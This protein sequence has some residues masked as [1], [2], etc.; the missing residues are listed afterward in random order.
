M[1]M[2]TLF[3]DIPPL[4]H[5]LGS[6]FQRLLRFWKICSDSVPNCLHYLFVLL[7]RSINGFAEMNC[8]GDGSAPTD[9][10]YEVK[11]LDFVCISDRHGHDRRI[12]CLCHLEGTL[13][14]RAKATITTARSLGECDEIH[15][16]LKILNSLLVCIELTSTRR[17]VQHHMASSSERLGKDGNLQ[18]LLF[19]NY[20]VVPPSH[21]NAD[22]RN[23][24][25]RAV[26]GNKHD[27]SAIFLENLLDVLHPGYLGRATH[28][29]HQRCGPN[30]TESNRHAP[31]L[32]HLSSGD[33]IHQLASTQRGV[34]YNSKSYC[35]RAIDGTEPIQF[36]TRGPK[37]IVRAGVE[38]FGLGVVGLVR[39]MINGRR[40]CCRVQRC[41][42][43]MMTLTTARTKQRPP[44]R[45]CL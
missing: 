45:R 35:H 19:G 5:G 36:Q 13:F 42:Q 7:S 21:I 23:V 40:R 8:G 15:T 1:A 18:Q 11:R 43:C 2:A 29:I 14:E 37:L 27:R 41:R 33:Q 16:I 26:I 6:S 34:P 4:V 25:P 38:W 31:I 32:V 30:L 9:R 24:H 44:C 12:D 17:T 39:R 20:F 28:E 22:K 10:K 3:S